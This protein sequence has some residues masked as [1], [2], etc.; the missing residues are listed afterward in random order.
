MNISPN[1]KMNGNPALKYRPDIDGLRCVAVLSVFIFHLMPWRMPGGFVGVDVFFVI[2]GYLIS[3]IMFSEIASR[4]FSVLRFYE[5]R[6]RR[7]LPAL[8]AML[9]VITVVM[10]VLLLPI[11]FSEYAKSVLA[12]TF[13]ASNFFFWTRSGY[14]DNP[15][16]NPLLHTWSLA[17]EEQFYILFPIFLVITR[18]FAP[19]KLKHGV[20]ALFLI[21]L[22]ASAIVVRQHPSAA[23]YMPYTRAW[24]LLLGTIISLGLFPRF[25]ARWYREAATL[26]GIGLVGY[27]VFRF[28]SQTPFPGLA[29]LVPCVGTAIIIAAGESGVSLVGQALSLRP[30]VF[31]G[32]IS[33]SLYLW[34]WPLIVLNGY[35]VSVS[36]LSRLPHILTAHMSPQTMNRAA[37]LIVAF[38][39]AT[40]SWRFV[41]R[42]FRSRPRRIERKPLFIA[43]AAVM[44]VLSIAAIAIVEAQGFPGRFPAR[45][46]QLASANAGHVSP[47]LGRLGNCVI[48]EGNQESVF[49][50]DACMKTA[51]GRDTYLLVGDSHAGALWEGLESALPN[52][53]VLLAAVW[54]CLPSIRPAG[55]ETCRRML[56]FVFN[57]YLPAHPVKGL[58]LEAR[59]SGDDLRGIGQ[60]VAWAKAHGTKVT[61]FG[62]VAEYDSS[63]PRLLAYS[64]AWRQPDLAEHHRSAFSGSLDAQMRDVSQRDWHVC[65]ASLYRASC[66]KGQC[67]EF[68]DDK[69]EVPLLRDADHLSEEGSKLVARRML[70]TGELSC[71]LNAPSSSHIASGT[72]GQSQLLDPP[73]HPTK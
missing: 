46:V 31:V 30:I 12:A 34:H 50:S 25:R 71:M 54:T 14:F 45:A 3:A 27:S 38:V 16:S 13:S 55:N 5:R 20:V 2:S 44:A 51:A 64:V 7:I 10:S 73:G 37:D 19:Q 60:V 33:Y 72:E 62:P 66:S 1:E 35:G 9:L 67:L 49:T 6:V 18:R 23:F 32:L 43:S 61:I 48:T 59:W 22:A 15:T 69:Q 63:L 70:E 68:A 8:F 21:S 41:E 42:P 17:V 28:S 24:E 4:Q 65:Y 56:D 26:V 29:A 39:L 47:T 36:I 58:L 40:L 53:N 52:S 57:K 11:E